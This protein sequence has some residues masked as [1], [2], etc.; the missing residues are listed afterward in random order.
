VVVKRQPPAKNWP[1]FEAPLLQGIAT[2][3]LRRRKAIVYHRA[4]SCERESSGSETGAAER[5]NLDASDLRLCVW[6]D[7]V[8]WFGVCVR[9]FGPGGGWAFQDNFHGDVQDV[10]AEA[11]VG[12]VEA[13]LSVPFGS[14]PD[15]ERQQ[16][17]DLWARVHPYS[18]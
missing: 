8:M 7:G 14:D 1:T 3:F 17:R 5:L 18:G 10:P 13:T 6:A 9:G 12:M 4:L 11:L 2:A 16:L 15:K